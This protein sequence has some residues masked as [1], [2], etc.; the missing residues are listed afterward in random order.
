MSLV[1]F[2]TLH[3]L[4]HVHA[5]LLSCVQFFVN[6]WTLAHQVPLFMGFPRQEHRWRFLVPPLGDLTDPGTETMSPES[7]ALAGGFFATEPLGT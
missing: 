1:S 6:P 7:S 2:I 3:T 4:V 5:H